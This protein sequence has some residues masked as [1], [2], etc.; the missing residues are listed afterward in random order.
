[1]L[2]EGKQFMDCTAEAGADIERAGKRFIGSIVGRPAEAVGGTTRGNSHL[3]HPYR[4]T[5]AR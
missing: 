1:M 5:Q 4:H 2:E 3:I